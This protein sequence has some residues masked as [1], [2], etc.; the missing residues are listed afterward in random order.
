MQA[1]IAIRRGAFL[2][3]VGLTVTGCASIQAGQTRTMEQML[4]AAGF[5]IRVAETPEAIAQLQ[6]LPARKLLARPQNGERQYAYAD[7]TGC[8]C[9]YVGTE[10]N[11]QEFRNLQQQ[12]RV[13]AERVHAVETQEAFQGLWRGV[14][15]P[16][17]Q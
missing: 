13:T 7:P 12:A 3:L 1:A 9:L 5:A 10:Q 6:T 17:L 15:P 8:R 16:P 2:F 11:Y 14:W 4:D